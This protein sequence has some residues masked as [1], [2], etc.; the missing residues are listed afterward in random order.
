[1]QY[2]LVCFDIENDRYR[3][4][5]G[6]RLLQHGHRVQRSVFEIALTN[7]QAMLQLRQSITNLQQQY[8]ETGNVRFYRLLKPCRDASFTIDGEPVLD[9][10][11]SIVV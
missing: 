11:A 9:F 4:R 1:M 10:P 6:K 8:E 2:Y 7:D 5:L 3:N